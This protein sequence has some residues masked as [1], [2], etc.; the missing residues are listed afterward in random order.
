[1]SDAF[2][3]DAGRRPGVPLAVVV[4]TDG[5]SQDAANLP[6]AVKRLH[7]AAD[8]VYAI[9]VSKYPWVAFCLI[10]PD[11]FLGKSVQ[12]FSFAIVASNLPQSLN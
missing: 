9:G 3:V 4:V 6:E 2:T 11:Q 1:M 5:R 10:V 12:P 8:R 7:A